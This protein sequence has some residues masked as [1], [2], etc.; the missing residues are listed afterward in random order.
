MN[1]RKLCPIDVKRKRAEGMV[2]LAFAA[3][4]CALQA[5][6]GRYFLHEHPATAGSWKQQPVTRLLAM[7]SVGTTVAHMSVFGIRRVGP[8]ARRS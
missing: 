5:N 6:A 1:Y 2:H 7:R 8:V 4:I 3:E